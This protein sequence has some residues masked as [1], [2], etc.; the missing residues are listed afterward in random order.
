MFNFIQIQN[1]YKDIF[2][3]MINISV[4]NIKDFKYYFISKISMHLKYGIVKSDIVIHTFF[5]I[6]YF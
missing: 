3:V 4:I 1:L 5:N 6:L 2:I